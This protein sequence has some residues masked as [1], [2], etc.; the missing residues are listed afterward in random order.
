MN[1]DQVFGVVIHLRHI[2]LNFGKGTNLGL[3]KECLSH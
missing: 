1:Q 2:I 3:I